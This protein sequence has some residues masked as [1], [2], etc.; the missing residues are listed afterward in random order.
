M[1]TLTD[2]IQTAIDHW[3]GLASSELKAIELGIHDKTN[4][5]DIARRRAKTYERTAKSLEIER[6]TGV[7]VCSCCHKPYTSGDC[8]FGKVKR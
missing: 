4:T 3:R 7:A 8:Q 6:D 1:S 5:A 2:D